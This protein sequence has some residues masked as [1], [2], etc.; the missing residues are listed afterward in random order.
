[1]RD[2]CCGTFKMR[3]TTVS[4]INN[5]RFHSHVEQLELYIPRN[6]E[7]PTIES[8]P[9]VPFRNVTLLDIYLSMMETPIIWFFRH[10]F[11]LSKYIHTNEL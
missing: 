6:M 1:M 9:N 10:I 8:S 5:H 3:S 11:P 4:K 7:R 2:I